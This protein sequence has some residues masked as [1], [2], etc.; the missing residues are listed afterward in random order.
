MLLRARQEEAGAVGLQW[1]DPIRMAKDFRERVD[2]G[3]KARLVGRR[4]IQGIHAS[5]LHEIESP[6]IHPILMTQ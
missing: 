5:L 2:I 3:R 6:L 1:R 4:G